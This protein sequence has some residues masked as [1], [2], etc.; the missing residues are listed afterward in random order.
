[1]VVIDANLIVCKAPTDF[2]MAKYVESIASSFVDN[3]T[4]AMVMVDNS[5]QLHDSKRESARRKCEKEIVTISLLEKR[6][7][8]SSML[9][10]LSAMNQKNMNL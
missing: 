3:G 5:V 1:M 4:R 8:L 2:N 9:Q 6:S 10:N 7:E